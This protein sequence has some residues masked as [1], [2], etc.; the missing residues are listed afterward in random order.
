MAFALKG[1]SICTMTAR[2][3]INQVRDKMKEQQIPILC[4]CM[5][6]QWAGIVFRDEETQPLTVYE[7]QWDA[8][9]KFGR[10]SKDRCIQ[11]IEKFSSVNVL[12][13][14]QMESVSIEHLVTYRFGNLEVEISLEENTDGDEV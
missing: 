8:I 7:L 1:R 2:K 6:G 14:H 10:M 4:E 9:K 13:Q 12:E 3:L 11:E 5:D